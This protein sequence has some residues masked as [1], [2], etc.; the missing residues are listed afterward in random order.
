MVENNM[1]IKLNAWSLD[2]IAEHH[3]VK[4]SNTDLILSHLF[5]ILLLI[6]L[7]ADTQ[8]LMIECWIT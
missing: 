1:T 2:K 3:R 5:F 8:K 6:G 4:Y 7:Q